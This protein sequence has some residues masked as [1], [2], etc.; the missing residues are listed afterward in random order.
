M[1]EDTETVSVV[2]YLL[3]NVI[4]VV[5]FA[6]EILKLYPF[7]GASINSLSTIIILFFSL[8]PV[9]TSFPN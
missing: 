3:F 7:I 8:S 6:F 5:F 9:P 4:F 2:T 1:L